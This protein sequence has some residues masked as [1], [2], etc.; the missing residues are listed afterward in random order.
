MNDMLSYVHAR[1]LARGRTQQGTS[2]IEYGLLVALVSV[3]IIG[4]VSLLGS[5]LEGM[6][7]HSAASIH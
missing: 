7:D 1:L 3:L 2:A 5:P 6:F 4:G